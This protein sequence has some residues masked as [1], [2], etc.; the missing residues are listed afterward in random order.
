MLLSDAD[1]P[2]L[3]TFILDL[4]NR[5][6]PIAEVDQLYQQLCD[7]SDL[8]RE[9]SHSKLY[10]SVRGLQVWNPLFDNVCPGLFIG[11]AESISTV[12]TCRD[13][14]ITLLSWWM[15]RESMLEEMLS[16]YLY[17][18]ID[19]IELHG[20]KLMKKTMF[21]DT[22]YYRGTGRDNPPAT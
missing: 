1:H 8:Y 15:E 4:F 22:F 10:H 6:G 9:V 13:L 20:D 14:D 12:N 18:G 5:T 2:E 19:S 16:G 3:R 11:Y 7:A 21:Q 17:T